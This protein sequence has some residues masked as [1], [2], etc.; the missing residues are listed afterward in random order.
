MARHDNYRD[1]DGN[2]ISLG[3]LDMAERKLIATL[4]RRASAAPDW[5]EFGNFWRS[6]VGDFYKARGMPRT[7]ITRTPVWRVAEDLDGRLAVDQGFARVPDYRDAIEEIILTRFK[8]RREFCQATGLS[9][10]MLSHVL[11]RR[12]HIAIDTLSKAL[13]RIGCALKIVVPTAERPPGRKS[14]RAG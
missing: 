2:E 13:S 6:L 9:E 5:H 10:D 8:S 12:K 14:R 3:S 7:R 4:K 11:A 1:L